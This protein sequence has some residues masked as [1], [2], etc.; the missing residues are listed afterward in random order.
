MLGQTDATL[1]AWLKVAIAA[2]GPYDPAKVFLGVAAAITDKGAA[3]TLADVVQATG[4]MGTRVPVTPWTTEYKLTD[5][6]WVV[7]GP[8]CVFQPLDASESQVV[9][10][11]FLADDLLAGNLIAWGSLGQA[12]EVMD[13]NHAVS[14]VPR[15][16]FDGSGDFEQFEVFEG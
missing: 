5:G 6:R 8:R 7:D 16:C 10:F 1:K 15:L 14:I 2:L 3:T 12:F 11:F 4:K 9:S 13:E